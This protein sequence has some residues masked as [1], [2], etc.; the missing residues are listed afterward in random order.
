MEHARAAVGFVLL[1]GLA[2]LLSS[3]RRRFPLRTVIGGVSLQIMLGLFVLKTDTGAALFT[4]IGHL[5][6]VIIDAS[7]AGAAFVFGNLYQSRPDDWGFV[8]AA[9]ALPTIVVF[10]SLSAI[11]YH[12]GILQKV[13]GLMARVMTR[14]M[15]ASGAESLSAAGNVFL[16]QTE[17]P[18][19]VRPYINGMTRSEL[20]AVM[21]GGFATM[22][23]SLIAVYMDLLGHHDQA[24][25]SEFARH[26]MTASLMSA[27]ASLVVARILLPETETPQT[28]GSVRLTADHETKNVVDAA[29]TGALIGLKLALNVAAM[30]IAFIAIIRLIDVGLGSVGSLPFLRHWLHG[31][32]IEHLTLDTLLGLLFAP[33]A[34]L[35]GNPP[36]EC[37]AFGSLLGKA[38]ATNEFVAYKSL[39]AMIA[40][41]TLSPRSSYLAV[42]ALCGFANF[43]S[44]AIQVAGIGALAP[45]RHHDLARLGLRAMLGGALT[46]W[47]TACIAG[48]LT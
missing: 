30:L 10:S 8:F 41:G 20:N 32:G 1:L 24:A 9:K 4:A 39:A 19:L 36:A 23:G 40:D 34:W 48:V 16:G 22:A 43:S 3:N 46:C 33:V 15:R 26:L 37:R 29:A 45:D 12:L 2:C 18:L 38:M 28:A 42:Y 27:P 47:M 25:M 14:L 31:H 21:V 5:V 11:G 17:A 7:D 44:V 13:V 6:T 35:I